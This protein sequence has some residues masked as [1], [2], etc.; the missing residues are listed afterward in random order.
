[1][2]KVTKI[3]TLVAAALCC[4]GMSAC[5]SNNAG[6]MGR[7]NADIQAYHTITYTV[8]NGHDIDVSAP[9]VA[10]AGDTVRIALDYY[11][12]DFAVDSIRVGDE[13]AAMESDKSFYFIMP[14]NDVNF[15]VNSRALG[16]DQNVAYQI[17]NS[18]ADLGVY[19]DGCPTEAL[20][21]EFVTF[22]V[23]MAYDSPFRFS[24]LVDGFKI[25]D[26]QSTGYFKVNNAYGIY[27]FEMPESDVRI[28]ALLEGKG[29]FLTFDKPQYVYSV[30]YTDQVSQASFE[31]GAEADDNGAYFIPF[32]AKVEVEFMGSY[33]DLISGVKLNEQEVTFENKT[34]V[35]FVMPGKDIQLEVGT[36]PWYRPIVPDTGAV[37]E[38]IGN[39]N[40]GLTAHYN[41]AYKRAATS[42]GTYED[43]D[44]AEA[45]YGDYVRIY[46]TP[47]EGYED[48]KI[49][50]LYVFYEDKDG[51]M[52]SDGYM[53][54]MSISE[55]KD[56]NGAYYQF[57]VGTAQYKIIPY[58][59]TEAIMQF[60]NYEFVGSYKVYNIYSET[61]STVSPYTTAT[62]DDFGIL[63]Q[64]STTVQL[65]KNGEASKATGDGSVI[66]GTAGGL[67]FYG[68]GFFIRSYYA[69]D[70]ANN[71]YDCYLGYKTT[72]SVKFKYRLVRTAFGAVE[73]TLNDEVIARCFYTLSSDKKI[74]AF[75]GNNVTFEFE[76]GTTVAASNAKYVVKANGVT[77]GTVNGATFTAA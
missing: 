22:T 68:G 37:D 31:R 2:K 13:Y 3:V 40:G 33:K 11:H 55:G 56:D 73:V 52:A 20:P 69:N 53:N 61:Y 21:G 66:A 67:A 6:A 18:N 1:M 51:N 24:G 19:L 14:D 74:T 50:K 43:F 48:R 45:L 71:T 25:T 28:D 44:P 47:K 72:E 10:K 57:S 49:S 23:S 76:T 38:A 59:Y 5:R 17:V 4:F 9:K 42:N 65:S 12:R 29:Y 63:K 46:A 75:Y 64:G 16:D 35:S 30:K 26:G 60:M 70:G 77:L 39:T 36:R 7:A 58:V 41:F 62:I 15:V 32:G 8:P 34:V 54:Q 27:Y